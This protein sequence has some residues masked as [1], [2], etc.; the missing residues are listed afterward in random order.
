MKQGI[1]FLTKKTYEGNFNKA[2]KPMLDILEALLKGSRPF[3][4]MLAVVFVVLQ[5]I[6]GFQSFNHGGRLE[7]HVFNII[8]IVLMATLVLTAHSWL[9]PILKKVAGL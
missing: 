6:K 4:A 8:G 2:F 3:I 1:I 9:L 7:K 5:L